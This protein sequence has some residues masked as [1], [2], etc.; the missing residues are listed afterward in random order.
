MGNPQPKLH[1]SYIILISIIVQK[2]VISGEYAVA[3]LFIIPVTTSLKITQGAFMMYQTVQFST[4]ALVSM[5]IPRLL[6]KFKYTTLNKIGLISLSCG[7]TCMAIAQNTCLL[8]IGGIF[9]GI[10]HVVTNYLLIGTLIPRWFKNNIGTAMATASLGATAACIIANPA[11][12]RLLNQSSVLG[13]ESWRGTYLLLALLPVSFGLANAFL[14]IKD[15]PEEMHLQ[16]INSTL[17]HTPSHAPDAENMNSEVSKN[18][19]VKSSSYRWLIAAVII[20]NIVTT[21]AA[22]VVAYVSVS[23]GAAAADFDLKGVIGIASTIGT[24]SGG[25]LIGGLNDKKGANTGIA[26]AGV[27][28]TIGFIMLYLSKEHALALL[29]GASI[30]GVF[31]SLANVQLPALITQM[32]GCRDYD[33][34]FP[35]VSSFGAWFGA[36]SASL[37]GFINDITGSYSM[38]LLLA[39]TL[40][41]AAAICG[42]VAVK[43]SESL[44]ISLK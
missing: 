30:T 34:I 43:K 14:L 3:G 5:F 2:F 37:W 7:I 19:A 8:Y 42:N 35:S 22:Y 13:M 29:A 10:G 26:L 28:G 11:V 6:S 41:A 17:G 36:F 23:P 32:Y 39:A 33:R 15:S 16:P 9:N 31:Y 38:T 27:C 44:K 24:L 40:S 18:T 25:Y 21:A 12:S 1:Y 20:W 4:L